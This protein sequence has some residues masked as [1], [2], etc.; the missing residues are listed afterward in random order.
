MDRPDRRVDLHA[1]GHLVGTDP[2]RALAHNAP[3]ARDHRTDP[4]R[5][6]DNRVEIAVIELSRTLPHARVVQHEIERPRQPGGGRLV[7]GEQEGEQLVA[8][9]AVGEAD[10][11][12]VAGR[13]QAGEHVVAL[14][15]VGG[16]AAAGDL[17]VEDLVHGA[18]AGVELLG[19]PA[20]VATA[21]DGVEHEHAPGA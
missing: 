2:E 18:P 17:G 7:P 11:V 15:Q 20:L 16:G 3:D 1:D 19:G 10:A 13:Q 5:L 4:Q 9:L 21:H 12:L 8:D 14:A 6:L